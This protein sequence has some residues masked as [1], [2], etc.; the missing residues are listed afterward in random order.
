MSGEGSFPHQPPEP[1]DV[2]SSGVEPTE[3]GRVL[4]FPS[5]AD[6]SEKASS[7]EAPVGTWADEPP[8]DEDVERLLR[9]AGTGSWQGAEVVEFPSPTSTQ[10]RR[11]PEFAR[12]SAEAR[13]REQ[14]GTQRTRPSDEPGEEDRPRYLASELLQKE[15]FPRAPLRRTLRWGSVALGVL[16]VG[17]TFALGGLDGNAFGLVA[18][19]ALC[20]VAGV[21]PL[22]AELRGAALGLIGASGAGWLGY[23][24]SADGAGAATPLLIACV[25]L[26]V[27]ALL[28]RAAHKTSKLARVLVG[29]GLV[30]V[31][32]YLVLTGGVDAMVVESMAWQSWVV[33][34][35]RFLLIATVLLG[36]LTFLDPTG[37]GGA[38]ILGGSLL[39]WLALDACGSLL[40]ATWPVRAPA[41]ELTPE[42]LL[43]MGA[44]PIFA[45]VTA[46]GLCQL[47]AFV[48]HRLH[49]K[50]A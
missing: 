17:T 24:S 25:T 3:G 43:V 41:A 42:R 1:D 34:V 31:A 48:S 46:G 36:A 19:F 11:R 27:A 2:E 10:R 21:V 18:L 50:P 23:L 7:S 14:T 39:G 44:L 6:A 13:A 33:P 45:A 26:T 49:G 29:V 4:E 20:A 9:P 15:W 12:R 22:E 35:S 30:A 5:E 8:G 38:W 16:G 28:F 32:G 47:L 37:H 40:V